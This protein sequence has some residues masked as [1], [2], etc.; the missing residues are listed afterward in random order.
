MNWHLV[1]DDGESVVERASYGDGH[2]VRM[3]WRHRRGIGVE[4]LEG[5]AVVFV[6]EAIPDDEAAKEDPL[7]AYKHDDEALEA[8]TRPDAPYEAPATD[9]ASSHDTAPTPEDHH[10]EAL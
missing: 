5:S 6:S 7:D 4:P 10:E 8:A 1:E 3:T 9:A 2:F